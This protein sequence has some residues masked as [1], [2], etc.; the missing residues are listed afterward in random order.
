MLDGVYLNQKEIMTE[1]EAL[2][3]YEFTFLIAA[4]IC[5]LF[6]T[7]VKK[8]KFSIIGERDKG[9][10][11]I[12]ETA[13][14]FFYVFAMKGEAIVAAPIVASYCIF[15]VILSRIFLKEKLS[16]M[17]YVTVALVMAGI[18]ILGISEGISEEYGDEISE[19]DVVT[20]SAVE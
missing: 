18:V 19:E 17:K 13:G 4:I 14:Q 15:S 10:A 7:V 6:I 20:V 8:E 12:F 11:A 2:L 16:K 3:A 9:F 1:D 5:L